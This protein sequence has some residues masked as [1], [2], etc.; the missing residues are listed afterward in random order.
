M[1]IRLISEEEVAAFLARH[2]PRSLR[3]SD[4]THCAC[5]WIGADWTAHRRR[6]L[7]ELLEDRRAALRERLL[8]EEGVERP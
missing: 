4:E 5:G 3:G 6:V 8:S 7:A 1:L 2:A